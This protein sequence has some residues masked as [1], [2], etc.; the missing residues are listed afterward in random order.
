MPSFYDIQIKLEA[1]K[2]RVSIPSLKKNIR[3]ILKALGWKQA[4]LSLLLAGDRKIR[5]L[6]QQ[7]LQHDRPTDVIAFSQL[8]GKPLR[9]KGGRPFL[10]D[11]VISLET[12][13]RQA[14]EFGNSFD[15]ELHF[16]IVHGILHLMGYDDKTKKDGKWMEEKQTM[17]LEKSLSFRTP[18][19]RKGAASLG[20]EKSRFLKSRISRRKKRSS[21]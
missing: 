11:I 7:Y 1:L 9:S 4:A 20:G 6:N 5:E 17:I 15:Y 16:Y 21:R 3:A 13:A 18:G 19:P 8:E 14:A 10:G 12:T 2:P